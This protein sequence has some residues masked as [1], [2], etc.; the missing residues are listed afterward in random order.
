MLFLFIWIVFV[1]NI[2]NVG[3]ADS[4]K[5]AQIMAADIFYLTLYLCHLQ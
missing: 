3:T 1:F 5:N 4:N 2:L